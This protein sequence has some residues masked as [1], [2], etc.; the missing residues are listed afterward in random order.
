MLYFPTDDGN[1]F[2]KAKTKKG[3]LY[4]FMD[5]RTGELLA[6]NRTFHDKQFYEKCRKDWDRAEKELP[7]KQHLLAKKI[8]TNQEAGKYKKTKSNDVLLIRSAI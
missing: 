1:F 5:P 3:Y 7:E 6:N 4:F 2:I 8:I